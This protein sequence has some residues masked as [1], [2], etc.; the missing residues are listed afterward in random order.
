MLLS[1]HFLLPSRVGQRGYSYYVITTAF[2]NYFAN[3]GVNLASLIPNVNKSPLEYLKNPS[4][5]SF[6]LLPITPT[7]I[8]TLISNL[9]SGKAA[10]PYSIPVNILKIVKHV[11]SVPLAT[12]FNSSISSG[13][14]PDNFKFA[15]VIPIYKKDSQT[16]LCNYR[17]IS[18]L[19]TFHKL[20]DKLISNRLLNFL[21]KENIFLR[22]NLVFEP[23]T[24][25]TMLFLV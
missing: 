9:K 12:V 3:V 5:N 16:N 10:G 21:E 1:W 18:L 20:V 7:E 8:E 22:G 11:I 19:S 2:N 24:Q 4:T 13:I 14:V 15:N 17:P 23:S 25:L 6:Y